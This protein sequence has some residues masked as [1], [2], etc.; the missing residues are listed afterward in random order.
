MGHHPVR[1]TTTPAPTPLKFQLVE[2]LTERSHRA[3][4][5]SSIP[6]ELP[7]TVVR[8]HPSQNE[9]FGY[10]D[11]ACSVIRKCHIR[12][13]RRCLRR[14]C[15]L[16]D[17]TCRRSRCRARST[18]TISITVVISDRPVSIVYTLMNNVTRCSH[19]ATFTTGHLNITT[20]TTAQYI[21][22]ESFPRLHRPLIWP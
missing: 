20:I 7:K 17:G 12:C 8:C 15:H 10:R 5:I 11:K 22:A 18:V 14:R 19:I 16:V 4:S 21:L 2:D 9:G 6:A 3:T 1:P 13:L